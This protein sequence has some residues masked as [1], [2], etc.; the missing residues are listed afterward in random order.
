MVA[1]GSNELGFAIHRHLSETEG[2]LAYAPASLSIALAMTYAGARGQ[3]ATEMAN[4]LSLPADPAAVHDGWATVL[5]SWRAR[6]E[7]SIANRLFGEAL[8]PF[9]PA[10]LHQVEA[11]YG[12]PLALAD[13]E[14]D[15]DAERIAINDW[16]AERTEGF[17]QDLLPPKSVDDTTVLVL[18]N[19]MY[20][21]ASWQTAF[22]EAETMDATFHA[23]DGDLEVPMMAA[24]LEA[25]FGWTEEATMVELPYDGGA[26]AALFVLPPAGQP[27]EAL[28][29]TLDGAAFEAWLAELETVKLDV[30]LPRFDVETVEPLALSEPLEALGMVSAF[31]WMTADFSGMS[32]DGSRAVHLDEVFQKV[33]VKVDEQGTEAAAATA[34]VAG[35]YDWQPHFT[36]NRPFLFFVYDRSST[37]VLFAGRVSRPG[38]S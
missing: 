32:A 11:S 17:I 1:R 21:D 12:A 36:A 9:A 38:G 26:M 25:R 33:V 24:R 20:F 31:D 7:L 18:A 13:F 10:F 28:E 4:A 2:N 3:T 8:F 37:A 15:A 14:Y 22:D 30:A 34:V 29:A 19:A 23:P 5:A 16:V 27:V 6:P 35:E